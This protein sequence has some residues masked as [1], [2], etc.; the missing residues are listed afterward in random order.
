MNDVKLVGQ[1]DVRDN[2]EIL[3][4]ILESVT[5]TVGDIPKKHNPQ[6]IL[7]SV[8][9]YGEE[10]DRLPH[11]HILSPDQGKSTSF[12]GCVKL[13]S[14]EHFIHGNHKSVFNSRQRKLFTSFIT[15]LSKKK[16]NGK[17]L[18]YWELATAY[19]NEIY[20]NKFEPSNE[21]MPDYSKMK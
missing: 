13:Y 4:S 5:R 3:D 11:M 7:F 21:P 17:R 14:A 6:E 1:F 8:F 15:S 18:T 9:V 20:N 2:R 19:W 16:Y 10:G 12:N